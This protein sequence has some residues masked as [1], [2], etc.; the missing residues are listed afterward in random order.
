MDKQTIL[1]ML[2][3][4]QV[5]FVVLWFSDIMGVV[6]SVIVPVERINEVLDRGVRFDGS[7]LEGF[8]RV[9]ESDMILTPDLDSFVI[10]PWDSDEDRSAR[11]ICRVQTPTG[12]PF[13]G[14]PRN[15]LIKILNK[16]EDMGYSLKI[17]TELEFYLFRAEAN[18]S[19][20]PLRT[21]DDASYFD[22]SNDFGQGIRRR[23]ITTLQQLG[24][25]VDSA[26]H[27]IG[28]GQHEIDFDYDD[29]LKIADLILTSRVAMR[30][31]AQRHG[32]H[33][34]FMP[35]P[36]EN[37]P[38]SGMHTH[39]SLHD[40]KTGYNIFSDP[41]HQY[42]L[43]ETAEQFLAGQLYHAKAMCAVLAP[44]VN[45]YKRL[46]T[47]FEAPKF[48]TWAHLNR[49][50]AAMIRVPYTTPGMEQHA[51]LELRCPDPSANPYLALAVMLAA[52][53][54]G[55]RHKMTLPPPTEETLLK[56]TRNRNLQELPSSLGEALDELS[57]DDVILDALGPFISDRFLAAKRQ[58]LDEY[59][60]YVTQ[61]ELN[62]YIT[63][64]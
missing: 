23:I 36:L 49:D 25:R 11:L 42:G 26:H 32:L 24:Y 47:S 60:G 18:Q 59:N 64:Y 51:R 3:A 20:F 46:S 2:E 43:S 57:H 38:G 50:G 61:W 52:G 22:I 5:R 45:S 56:K 16:A 30:T 14:D 35:R 17:G 54:D 9:A 62:R 41:T 34:T 53:L 6:K 63:R 21:Y 40:V 39:Q 19:L 44:L 48:I 10:L 8:A 12:E 33:C 29:A 1:A 37:A 58:E 7:S 28:A 15:A 55:I 27:E 4:E 13:I 31:V